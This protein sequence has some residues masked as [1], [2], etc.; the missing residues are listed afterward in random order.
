MPS[1]VIRTNRPTVF[2]NNLKAVSLTNRRDNVTIE[3]QEVTNIGNTGSF[4][5][6]QIGAALKSTQE[7]NIDY[8]KFENH[9]FFNSAVS[10][11]NVSFDRI[12]NNYPFDSSIKEI[13]EFE[14]N[15]TGFEKYI[16][17]NFSKN[18][19]FLLF[20]GTNSITVPDSAGQN[21]P[22]LSSI[23]TGQS[24]L[25]PRHNSF[26]FEVFCFPA[27][28]S[29]D[30]Q[31][32]LQKRA[33]ESSAITLALSSSVSTTECSALF[34]VSCNGLHATAS[35]QV[36]KGQFNHLY[37]EYDAQALSSSLKIYKDLAIASFEN[38]LIVFDDLNFSA[39]S[40]SI[41][42][43]STHTLGSYN[44]A[45][46]EMLSGALDE[47]R[48]FHDTIS[49]A[50]LSK[51]WKREI[52]K[53]DN[54]KLY[55]KFN[56]PTGSY[57]ANNVVLDYSGNSL[58]SYIS[59]FA[60]S[61]RAGANIAN[62]MSAEDLARCPV[63]FADYPVTIQ[64]N[65]DLLS[66]ATTYDN[67]NPNLITKI[68]PA[69]YLREGFVS[70]G[71]TDE[72]GAIG[73]EFTGES[74]PGTGRIGSPQIISA[75]LLVYAK[76]FDELKTFVDHFSNLVHVDYQQAD[77]I[78]DKFLP[79]LADYYG[80]EVPSLF[81]TALSEQFYDG[82]NVTQDN[83]KLAQNLDYVRKQ[84]WRRMLVNMSSIM[85]EKGT[86]ASVRSLFNAA[87]IIPDNFFTIREFGGP[88]K[89][90]LDG[91]RENKTEI[92]AMLDFSGSLS[93]L[94][95]TLDFQGFSSTKPH[96]T[97]SY[98]SGSRSEP[99][100]PSIAGT[101]SDGLFTSGSFTLES[102]VKYVP[103]QRHYPSESLFRL[104]VTGTAAPSNQHGVIMNVVAT[105]G[106]TEEDFSITLFVRPVAG[107]TQAIVLPL[108]GVNV[109]DGNKWNIA[110]GR[111]RSDQIGY[112][113]SS[114]FLKVAKSLDPETYSLYQTSAFYYDDSS[115]N[116]L[117]N[118]SSLNTSGT[119]V[120]FGSQSL[121]TSTDFLNGYTT[122]GA[123]TNFSGRVAQHRVWSKALTNNE[124]TS[125]I[126]N[127]KSLGIENPLIN[128][129]FDVETT[130]TFERLR[131]DAS[132]DQQITSSDNT[133]YLQIFD[134]S[135]NN[136]SMNALSFESNKQIIKPETFY[137]S[138]LSPNFDQSVS[139][140]KVRVR[141]L[142][143]PELKPNI[144]TA[145]LAPVYDVIRSEI[146]EDDRRFLIEYSIIKA[147]NED[148]VRLLSDLD[149][150]NGALGKPSLMYDEF[151][152]DIEQLRKIYFSRLTEKLNY[153]VFFDLFKWFD[154]SYTDIVAS[155]LPKQTQFLGINYTIESHMLERHKMR[156]LSDQQYL[157]GNLTTQEY[158]ET[159][160][161]VPPP[162]PPPPPAPTTGRVTSI[163]ESIDPPL[164][165]VIDVTLTFS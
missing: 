21:F 100:Y 154:T 50:N 63:L 40:V 71:F 136:L 59:N 60:V 109:F 55:F 104:H 120:V 145:R 106:S 38:D 124:F 30:N 13:E 85:R 9:T 131:V 139:N 25:D 97:G 152:P 74:M 56:E 92:A 83:Q 128:F 66:E 159:S 26:S 96:I 103:R 45:P 1:S 98:L 129:S 143:Y 33:N 87:G 119:F 34:M 51:N 153:K 64:Y 127:F 47:L 150:F 24:V 10:K 11:V 134:F 95:G 49:T 8:T 79:F 42:S 105:S 80:F 110:A 39:A 81:K 53:T 44:F 76:F 155:L 156:Y 130:G 57:A 146:P 18:T 82:R 48:F 70:Q 3:N 111:Q 17:D 137:Y 148:I 23:D 19:N 4:R 32:I 123:V 61:Q 160:A 77:T 62:P 138:H 31:I 149:F 73:N 115:S 116:V 161:T 93:S 122:Q 157:I 6:D 36:T 16:L 37:F 2:S 125:H 65:Q 91:R 52:Y 67:D 46:Q 164:I 162:R 27:S 35:A 89:N 101:S 113:S 121:A 14:D 107:A 163:T 142:Q 144:N 72:D 99:G 132:F 90:F 88:K 54:L 126:Q 86:N 75:M 135:Q 7:L 68:I 15:L 22:A 112:T 78:S 84:L 108:T 133:G 29:N 117:Q 5:Y 41:G 20:D 141:S 140:N 58:H 147:L 12:I 43:G 151:Y 114:Y 102:I 158:T 165:D 94:P 118:I 69:H 28:K